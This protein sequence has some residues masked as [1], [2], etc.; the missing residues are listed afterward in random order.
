MKGSISKTSVIGLLIFQLASCG[1]IY[2]T[3]YRFTP[4]AG[5]SAGPA[6]KSAGRCLDRCQA[7]SDHCRREQADQKE[8][9]EEQNQQLMDSCNRKILADKNRPANWTE[10]GRQ[11]SCDYP[12]SVCDQDYRGCY[13]ECGGTVTEEQVCVMN[14]DQVGKK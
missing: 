5:K 9:C 11:L 4:P 14:C 7:D 10:C 3:D 6:G 1:P 2:S 13:R 8:F 12:E